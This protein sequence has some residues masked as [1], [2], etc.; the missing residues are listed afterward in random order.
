MVT[1][2]ASPPVVGESLQLLCWGC[3]RWYD[4]VVPPGWW[5]SIPSHHSRACKRTDMKRQATAEHFAGCPRPEKVLFRR[6]EEADAAAV[7]QSKSRGELLHSY[8]C[9]CGGLHIGHVPFRRPE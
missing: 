1:Q 3:H 8:R 6:V 7:A 4:W 5:G 2:M 9:S